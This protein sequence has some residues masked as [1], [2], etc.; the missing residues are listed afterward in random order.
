MG[1]ISRVSSRTYRKNKNNHRT[2][3][4][5]HEVS[6]ARESCETTE[7][8]NDGPILTTSKK[9]TKSWSP[10][11]VD[12]ATPSV[13]SQVSDSRSSKSPVS[14]SLPSSK[15]RKNDHVTRFLK[16]EKKQQQQQ[17][18]KPSIYDKL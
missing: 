5:S 2:W 16:T 13:I 14:P 18:K 17:Q 9:T 6:N 7:G 15:A 11:S 10:D 3:E 8:S 12:L 4:T 1:L